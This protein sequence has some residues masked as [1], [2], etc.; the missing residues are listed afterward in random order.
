MYTYRLLSTLKQELSG[1]KALEQT[2]AEEKFVINQHIFH[3][4]GYL[5]CTNNHISLDLLLIPADARL[6]NYLNF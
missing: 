6:L 3:S 1:T 5:N 2:S 4:T